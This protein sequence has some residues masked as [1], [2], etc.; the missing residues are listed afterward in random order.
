MF[1]F[2]CNAKL[3]FFSFFPNY[4][5]GKLHFAS[6]SGAGPHPASAMR[7]CS[8]SAGAQLLRIGVMRRGRLPVC[9]T[10]KELWQ[11]LVSRSRKPSRDRRLL[12]LGVPARPRGNSGRHFTPATHPTQP[13]EKGA[14]PGD[15]I[16]PEESGVSCGRMPACPKGR[17]PRPPEG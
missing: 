8:F 5:Q 14:K 13:S 11:A 10:I 3:S 9:A 17:C 6:S 12:L 15:E 1:F 16:K 7:L 4:Q 2:P